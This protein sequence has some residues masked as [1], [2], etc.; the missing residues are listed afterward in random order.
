MVAASESLIKTKVS[1]GKKVRQVLDGF[2]TCFSPR[3]QKLF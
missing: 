3:V 2:R 1:G